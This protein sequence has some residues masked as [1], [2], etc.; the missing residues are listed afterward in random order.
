MA[1]LA[2]LRYRI[3]DVSFHLAHLAFMGFSAF[4]WICPRLRPWHLLVQALVGLSWFALGARRGWG[5]CWLTDQQWTHKAAHG[6]R[7]ATGS[8]VEHW[9]N[10]ILRWNLP[11]ARVQAAILWT[12]IA[13]TILSLG[14]VLAT[15]AGRP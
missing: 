10:E 4:G 9:T 14:L 1:F 6:R 3:V 11:S 13:T 12:W 2:R 15:A 5:Y 7:P 8:F